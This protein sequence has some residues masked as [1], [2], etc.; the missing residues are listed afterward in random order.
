MSD[1][2][3]RLFLISPII[4]NAEAF[5]QSLKAALQGGRIDCLLLRFA[6]QD[7]HELKRYIQMLAPIAQAQGVAV[8][9]EATPDQRFAARVGA[10]GVHIRYDTT[11]LEETCQAQKPDRIVGVSGIKSRDDAMIA[12]EMGA[13]YIMFGEPYPDSA[14]PEFAGVLERASWWAEIFSTP[15]VAYAPTLEAIALLA[16][17]RI[18][19]IALDSVIW[20]AEAG[21]TKAVASALELITTSIS[22]FPSPLAGEGSSKADG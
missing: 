7:E 16:K 1:I 11:L 15:C 10:D 3:P 21:A 4:D 9:I 22:T 12:G 8:L 6:H 13:D 17:A 5:T 20:Q 2:T 19:F 18:E 14:L